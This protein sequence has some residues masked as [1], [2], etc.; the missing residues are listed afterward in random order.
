MN[1]SELKKKLKKL[2]VDFEATAKKSELEVL[3]LKTQEEIKEAKDLEKKVEVEKAQ[4]KEEIK[5]VEKKEEKAGVKKTP[6]DPLAGYRIGTTV[7][8]SAKNKLINGR[9]YV[10]LTLADNTKTV[11]S[12][13][14]LNKQILK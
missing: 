9:N 2:D 12:E 8:V 7:I 5:K 6:K 14:D 4:V 1:I 10:E 13:K 11:L 3:L